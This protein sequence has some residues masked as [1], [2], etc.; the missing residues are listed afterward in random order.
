MAYS[1][2]DRRAERE[3]VP[4]ALSNGI[5]LTVW[6]PLVGG[7]LTG[8]Y[9]T[10]APDGSRLSPGDQAWGA[11]HFTTAASTAV[12]GLVQI[13]NEAGLSL[14]AMSL[15]WLLQRPGI[16]SVVLGP[17]NTAQFA[18]QLV[19]LDV[20]LSADV[21]EAIDQV[22]PPGSMAVPYFLDDSWADFRPQPFGW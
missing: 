8:K 18:E 16:S 13:A 5:G 9:L 20:S 15:A 12:A 19:A 4:A 22:V 1:L 7:L 10:A 21:L 3:L 17:R 2:L 6:S 14:T 11:R